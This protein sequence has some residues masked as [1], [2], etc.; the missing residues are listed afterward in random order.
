MH[1]YKI[2]NNILLNHILLNKHII[3]SLKTNISVQALK[4]YEL[5]HICIS[6]QQIR[7][8]NSQCARVLRFCVNSV[9]SILILSLI[10]TG[11]RN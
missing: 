3:E 5:I 1:S 7:A 10:K 9:L 6:P 11:A 4:I 2:D 8:I